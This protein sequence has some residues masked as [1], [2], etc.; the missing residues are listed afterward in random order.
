MDSSYERY[1]TGV[2]IGADI[3]CIIY[4]RYEVWNHEYL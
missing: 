4:K 2:C 1:T 3:I